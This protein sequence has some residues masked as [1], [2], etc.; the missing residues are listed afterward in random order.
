MDDILTGAPGELVQICTAGGFPLKK[1]S[2]N[3]ASLL[4]DLSKEDHLQR[5]PR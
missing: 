5:E 2:A 4:E 1:W 3:D